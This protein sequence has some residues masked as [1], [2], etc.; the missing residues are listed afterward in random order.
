MLDQNMHRQYML[1]I[2]QDIFRQPRSKDLALKGGTL[3]YFV[4]QLDR[5]ST[6]LDFDV[7]HDAL[8]QD[9]IDKIKQVL[10][11]HGEIKNE[12]KG[13]LLYRLVF[14]YDISGYN[15]KV[16]LNTRISPYNTYEMVNLYGTD[17]QC[18]KKEAI[19][20]NKL[21]A[22]A[23]REAGRDIYDVR[24]MYQQN[25]PFDPKI[26]EERSGKSLH[27]FFVDTKKH[28]EID[29]DIKELLLQLG[30]VLTPAQKANVK[31]KLIPEVLNI[32][33]FRIDTYKAK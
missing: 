8:N 3:C 14:R 33:Q 11:K 6:D 27:Q 19:F 1:K 13:K 2:L 18:M 21:I 15:I 23:N 31:T 4:Y 22:L 12:T 9:L 28:L 29:F 7:L 25:F 24:R 32:L 26:I 20:A 16:E 10:L 30:V 17:I 5:F